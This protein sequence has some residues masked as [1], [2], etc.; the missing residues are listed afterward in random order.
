MQHDLIKQVAHISTAKINLPELIFIWFTSIVGVPFK[1][2]SCEIYSHRFGFL[3]VPI[4]LLV[5]PLTRLLGTR[6]RRRHP[7]PLCQMTH[8]HHLESHRFMFPL[9]SSVFILLFDGLVLC[10]QHEPSAFCPKELAPSQLMKI[11][12]QSKSFGGM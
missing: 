6:T 1:H 7:P 12:L 5:L 4:L 10:L 11:F 9:H 8:T 3:L 2:P